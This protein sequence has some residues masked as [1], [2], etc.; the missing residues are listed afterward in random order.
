MGQDK[1][2]LTKLLGFVAELYNN[3]DNEEFAAGIRAIVGRDAGPT[4]DKHMEDIYEHCI[5]EKAQKQAEA[6]YA[7]FPIQ[8]IAPDLINSYHLMEIFRRR[9]DF[10]HFSAEMFKQ[11][12]CISGFICASPEYDSAFHSIAKSPALVPWNNAKDIYNRYQDGPSVK[13]LLFGQYSSNYNSKDKT[14]VPLKDQYISD[15]YKIVLY[16]AGYNTKVSN[17]S[18]FWG[19]AYGISDIYLIRCEADHGTNK[20]TEAQEARFQEIMANPESHYLEFESTFNTFVDKIKTGYPD[21]E[22]V[23]N[24]AKS[25][26]K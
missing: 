20:R 17:K 7:D 25:I 5:E 11:I 23:F 12:E 2:Q 26:A 21:R 15:K 10:V 14:N 3:P 18:E 1:R 6:Y 13:T 8:E 19:T 16:L 24:Y 9:G 22:S 4:T